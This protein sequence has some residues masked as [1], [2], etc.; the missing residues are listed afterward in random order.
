MKN[1]LRLVIIYFIFL[2]S[3]YCIFSQENIVLPNP[4]TQGGR[5]L[6]EV[7]KDRKSSRNFSDKMLTD[8]LLSNLLWAAN[9]IN[10][11]DEGKRTAPSTR[12]FQE[13]DIYVAL[14][15]GLYLY[16]AKNNQLILVLKED[17]R[18]QTGLQNFVATA[19]VNLI[20]V[21]DLNK[22]GNT[23]DN[24]KML[25]AYADASFISQNVYLFCASEG[26]ATV[27]RG[28]LDRE[29]LSKTMKLG[30]HQKIIMAQTVGYPK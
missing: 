19:P 7:L 28:Y 30:S 9:G 1:I 13:I 27:V 24:D 21:A 5:P 8:Q 23:A 25:Y 11:P 16:D 3:F 4:I 2:N 20:F 18:K 10:R 15:K 26:L 29:Q 14:P 17:I 22:M 6:M 12:N